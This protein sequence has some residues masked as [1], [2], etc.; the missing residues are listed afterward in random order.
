L[1]LVLLAARILLI[2]IKST[3]G[4]IRST[5]RLEMKKK[6]FASLLLDLSILALVEWSSRLPP[7]LLLSNK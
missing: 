4:V 7:Y 1:K 2:V 3:I 5:R 6:G